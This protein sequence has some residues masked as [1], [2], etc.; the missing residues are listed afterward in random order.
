[1]RTGRDGRQALFV[2][3]IDGK[4]MRRVS[5]WAGALPGK[6]AWSEGTPRVEPP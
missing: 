1:V 2:V 6:V 4:G 5:P 3:A